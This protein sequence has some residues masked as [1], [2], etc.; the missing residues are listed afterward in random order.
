MIVGYH[1]YAGRDYMVTV[2]TDDGEYPLHHVVRHSPDGFC[3]GYGGSGPSDLALSLLTHFLSHPAAPADPPPHLYQKF[4]FDV[5]ANLP[6][7][8]N[9]TLT[10]DQVLDWYRSQQGHQE[11]Q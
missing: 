11:T 5:V 7:S 6:Q 9:W 10:F 4:K 2:E 3:W 8:K 1:G